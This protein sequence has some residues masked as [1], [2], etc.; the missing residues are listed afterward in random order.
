VSGVIVTQTIV[1]GPTAPASPQSSKKTNTGAI[2]GGVV[3]GLAVLCAIAG[4]VI[5]TLWRRRKQQ[6]QEEGEDQSGVRRNISTMSKSGLLGPEKR[7]QYPP[8]IVTNNSGRGSR[9]LDNDSISPI[10]ASDRRSSRLVFDQRLNPSAIMILDN[11]SRESFISMD[12]SRD[13]GRTLNV[14]AALLLML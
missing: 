12:D 7:P 3:G 1:T 10:S 6:Q 14:C 8:A 11:P 9:I 13:Y 5:F 2:V 4:A